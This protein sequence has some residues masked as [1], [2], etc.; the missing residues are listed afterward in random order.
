MGRWDRDF[1]VV[2]RLRPLDL[3][4][5]VPGVVTR[6]A[7]FRS[8]EKELASAAPMPRAFDLFV[9]LADAQGGRQT[10]QIEA[11]ARPRSNTGKRIFNR[12]SYAHLVLGRPV[13][14]VVFYLMPAREGRR[15]QTRYSVKRGSTS[16]DFLFQAV[17]LWWQRADRLLEG[18]TP[19]CGL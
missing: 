17:C 6:G 13:E 14:C 10:F 7:R 19:G 15:P 3:L 11:E 2:G 1:K 8:L 18:Q 12:W 9:E 5:L 4:G 16:V